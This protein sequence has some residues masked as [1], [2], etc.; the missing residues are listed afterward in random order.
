MIEVQEGGLRGNRVGVS[1]EWPGVSIPNPK[2]GGSV[3]RS[4]HAG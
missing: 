1:G 3:C 2:T 4:N